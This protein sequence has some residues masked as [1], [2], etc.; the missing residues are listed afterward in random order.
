[1]TWLRTQVQRF[2]R[3]RNDTGP[4]RSSASP[5]RPLLKADISERD[6]LK[7]SRGLGKGEG[8]GMA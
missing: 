5:D 1:M 6:L 7:Q 3:W 8:Q 4:V 2:L